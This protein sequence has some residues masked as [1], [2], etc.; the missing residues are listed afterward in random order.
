MK[1]KIQKFLIGASVVVGVSAI[2]TSS[3]LAGTLTRATITGTAPNDFE[4]WDVDP[5]VICPAPVCLG[6]KGADS[7]DLLG[8]LA[9]TAAQPGGNVELFKSSETFSLPAF[10]AYDGVTSLKVDFVFDDSPQEFSVILSSLTAVDLFG[11]ALDTS[12][13]ADTVATR[14]FNEALDFNLASNNVTENL[15]FS[16]L[17][18][19]TGG[20][21]ASRA[22]LYNQFLSRG[23]FQRAV[24]PNIAFF[25]VTDTGEEK[26]FEFGLAGHADLLF[27]APQFPQL[28]AAL[29]LYPELTLRASEL[30]KVA[31]PGAEAGTVRYSF[32]GAKSN[33]ASADGSFNYTYVIDPPFGGGDPEDPPT[34]VP[35]PSTMLGLMAVGGLLA[36]QRK[37]KNS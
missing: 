21:I 23:G 7:S 37:L 11:K 34:S 32:V 19:F 1:G 17:A 8:I 5:S 16:G 12:F 22:D 29:A 26:S 14:W 6:S 10:L 28:S 31:Y 35:E 33:V 20:A 30:V 2:A 4:V 18:Q 13:T 25:T 27:Y 24:D 15:L 36:A 9:G 3:A